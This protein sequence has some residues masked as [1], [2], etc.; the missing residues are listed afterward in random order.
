[1][2]RGIT[3]Q[4]SIGLL[5]LASSGS[6]G[7]VEKSPQDICQNAGGFTEARSLALSMAAVGLFGVLLADADSNQAPDLVSEVN[8]Q[9]AVSKAPVPANVPTAV[10]TIERSSTT[11]RISA[12]S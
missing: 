9:T 4:S 12:G 6:A 2:L 7:D 10:S 8:G 1:M 11:T 5:M 3:K